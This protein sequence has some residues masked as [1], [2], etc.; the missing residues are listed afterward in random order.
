[1]KA[2]VVKYICEDK[3]YCQK[4]ENEMKKTVKFIFLTVFILSVAV[5]TLGS[6]D[7][8][9]DI[10]GEY[11][12]VHDWSEWDI[13][14]QGD[15]KTPRITQRKCA[16][17]GMVEEEIN[18]IKTHTESGW[19][20]DKEANCTEEGRHHIEC[21]IC[22]TI[23]I[24][25]VTPANE[26]HVYKDDYCAY[27]N[28]SVDEYFDFKIY[29]L[30]MES[31]EIKRKDGVDFL[32][33]ISLPDTYHGKPVTSIK[34]YAFYG[35]NSLTSVVIPNSVTA[36]GDFAFAYCSSLEGVTMPNG[37]SRIG[38]RAFYHCGSLA[39]VK[40]PDDVEV[41]GL[42]AFAY[43]YRLNKVV[44]GNSV[45][46][47]GERAFYHCESLDYVKIRDGVTTIS[48]EAFAYCFVLTNVDIPNSITTIENNAFYHCRKLTSVKI[49]PSVTSIGEFVF[50]YCYN[51][52]NVVI[53][54][55]VT[56]ISNYAFYKCD[57]LTDIYYNGTKEA[58]NNIH[59][60][61]YN[62]PLTDATCYYYSK[63]KPTEEG[64]FWHW[65]ENGEV[66]VW[67]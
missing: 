28:L 50:A 42:E 29:D 39:S 18:D 10:F 38:E 56:T 22:K 45:T 3:H 57:S 66:V 58:W 30:S 14:E 32:G 26:N 13:V 7:F 5:L 65:G 9:S 59:I 67:E 4:G 37:V 46:N 55:S 63:T 64:N 53:P 16:R 24:S 17:C 31:Y 8:M 15:C 60:G 35:C 61:N 12:C 1:M 11:L 27:C 36:I 23:I 51:L 62:Y 47:I 21:I 2:R 54:D 19:L 41:I 25:E 6:C 40:I 34:D 44:F 49:P 43:C 48:Y 20:V 52:S 33:A